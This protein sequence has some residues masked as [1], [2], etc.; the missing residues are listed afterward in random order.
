M[1]G[2]TPAPL[3]RLGQNALRARRRI[4]ASQEAISRR[5]GIHRCDVGDFERGERN[6][7]IFALVSFAGSLGIAVA[8]L[9]SETV[10]WYVRPLP[11]PEYAPGERRPT[12]SERDVAL[13]RLWRE[14]KTERE[15]AVRSTSLGC[16]RARALRG[17]AA[18]RPSLLPVLETLLAWAGLPFLFNAHPVCRVPGRRATIRRALGRPGRGATSTARRRW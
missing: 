5:A 15:I 1:P 9:F 14:G 4:G 6:F 10:D 16:L 12:K 2:R 11:E 8:E 17:R 3:W 18:W 7:R 13:V